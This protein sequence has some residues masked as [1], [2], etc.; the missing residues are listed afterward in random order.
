MTVA[1]SP[2]RGAAGSAGAAGAAGS[3]GTALVT[4]AARGI[5]AAVTR[6]LVGRGFH[7]VAVDSCAGED[8]DAGYPLATRADL[9][10]V[11]AA[12]PGAVTPVVADARDVAAMRTVAERIDTE[13]G[14]LTVVVA[15]AAIIGGGDALW[16]TDDAVL[17]AI[18][19]SD[20]VTVWNTAKTMVPL[21][22]RQE[23]A[24]RPAFVAITS[25]AGEHGLY[26]LS[27]YCMVKH[28][29]VGL[30]RG[31]AADV[32]GQ[33]LTVAGV[34]PG[35]T[36]TQM[37]QATARLYHLDGIERLVQEQA[38]G[39]VLEPDEVAAVVE[40]AALAGPV[41]HGSILSASGGFR[42]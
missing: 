22:L 36:D 6:R 5:G 25:G 10:A 38:I 2:E 7:V 14:D 20:A 32:V 31:L 34:S 1:S 16:D 35:S 9:D 37:L 42:S 17:D 27:A 39:R 28:A 3:A 40:F 24:R 41:V 23:A 15:G 4:G 18:W 8:T 11:A 29:V 26:H 13:R 33:H 21:L 30:V 12:H 19:R